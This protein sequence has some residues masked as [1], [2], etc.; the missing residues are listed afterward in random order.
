[1]LSTITVPEKWLLR[2]NIILQ[3]FSLRQRDL[4]LQEMCQFFKKR[5]YPDSTVTTGR[6]HLQEIDRKTALQTSQSEKT[7]W[8]PYIRTYHPQNLAVKDVILKNFK[9]LR[10]DP[11]TKHIFHLPPLFSFKREKNTG[12]FVVRS[13]FKSDNQPGNVNAHDAK[14]VPLF[15]TK[16]RDLR[17]ESIR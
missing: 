1:M 9:T 12:N 8:I 13:A 7:N 16:L 10:N 15:L 5:G 2:W 3:L 14:L 17:T 4:L 6:H 11:E